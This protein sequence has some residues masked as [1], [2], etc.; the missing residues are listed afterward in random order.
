MSMKIASQA[1]VRSD[2]CIDKTEA[3]WLIARVL[4]ERPGDSSL[5]LTG[6]TVLSV[7][8]P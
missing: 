3:Q 4:D 1:Q 5:S 7:L 8:C 6:T 2:R